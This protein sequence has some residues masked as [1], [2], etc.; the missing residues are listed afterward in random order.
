M[1]G[2]TDD[3][4]YRVDRVWLGPPGVTFPFK[5]R[6]S[7]YGVCFAL[8]LLVTVIERGV[9][10]GVGFFS[11]AWTLVIA[12]LVTRLIGRVHNW[13]RP[14]SAI[15]GLALREINGPRPVHKP[16]AGVLDPTGVRM[17]ATR[18]KRATPT[19]RTQR[20]GRRQANRARA[21]SGQA[22]QEQL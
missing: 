6:Y 16:R 18:P 19:H 17:S 20:R 11:L 4:V 9:G 22:E 21:S 14:L 10:I 13:E 3:S 12:V 2:E 7:S 5:A 1:L 15:G 8:F